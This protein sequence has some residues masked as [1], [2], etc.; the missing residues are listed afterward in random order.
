MTGCEALVKLTCCSLAADGHLLVT[1]EQSP[2]NL[3]R[4]DANHYLQRLHAY[5]FTN[6]VHVSLNAKH[7]SLCTKLNC[8]QLNVLRTCFNICSAARVP[9]CHMWQIRSSALALQYHNQL[10]GLSD[11]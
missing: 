1:A 6:S 2:G 3:T 9:A 8:I 5:Y 4:G 11:E 10:L 7:M